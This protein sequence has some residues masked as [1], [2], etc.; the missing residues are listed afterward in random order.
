MAERKIPIDAERQE[1]PSCV[2]QNS[3][4]L[5]LRPEFR[6][7]LTDLIVRANLDAAFRQFTDRIQFQH[8]AAH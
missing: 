6:Q 7:T 8:P 4:S 1:I 2:D 5:A 3:A